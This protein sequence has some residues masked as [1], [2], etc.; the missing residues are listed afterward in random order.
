MIH[1]NIL[2]FSKRWSYLLVLQKWISRSVKK[3]I[4][5][6]VLEFKNWNFINLYVKIIITFN[7]VQL[8]LYW[9]LFTISEPSCLNFF[10]KNEGKKLIEC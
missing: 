5:L 8:F 2:A 3:H 4:E 9:K 10:F 1:K 6:L 7:W